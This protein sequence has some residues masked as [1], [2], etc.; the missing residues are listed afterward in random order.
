M[1]R[2]WLVG[3][4]VVALAAAAPPARHAQAAGEVAIALFARPVRAAHRLAGGRRRV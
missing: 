4:L 2:R 1:V 3:A